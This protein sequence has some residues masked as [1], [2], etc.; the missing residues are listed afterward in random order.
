MRRATA[1]TEAAVTHDHRLTTLCRQVERTETRDSLRR[2][3]RAQTR[4]AEHEAARSI[5][6]WDEWRKDG[7]VQT[8]TTARWRRSYYRAEENGTLWQPPEPV[9]GMPHG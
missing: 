3:A 7:E 1:P 5:D 8:R 4:S 9:T 2:W 6:R